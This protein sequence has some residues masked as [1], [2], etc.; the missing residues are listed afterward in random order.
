M[1]VTGKFLDRYIDHMKGDAFNDDLI[2]WNNKETG[3]RSVWDSEVKGKNKLIYC[4][5]NERN[6][7]QTIPPCRAQN[8]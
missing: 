7:K 1:A 2:P 5:T 3:L 4:N 8:L 6:K